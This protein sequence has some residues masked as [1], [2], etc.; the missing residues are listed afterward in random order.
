MESVGFS[1]DEEIKIWV[2]LNPLKN[3]GH[4][5]QPLRNIEYSI[6]YVHIISDKKPGETWPSSGG[7]KF[8]NVSFQY[9]KDT[10][11]VLKEMNFNIL[12]KEKVKY[13]TNQYI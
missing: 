1:Q 7:V 6:K 11:Y 8:E 2:T 3:E 12:P 13:H 10:K 9:S 5:K 4:K